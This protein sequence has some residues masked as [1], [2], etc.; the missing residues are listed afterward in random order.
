MLIV[1]AL[2]PSNRIFVNNSIAF[3]IDSH[4]N[5]IQHILSIK[6]DT[7]CLVLFETVNLSIKSQT[8][9]SSPLN[10]FNYGTSFKGLK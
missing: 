7:L 8:T 5:L 6:P 1:K 9:H 10:S 4:L 3:S 2:N